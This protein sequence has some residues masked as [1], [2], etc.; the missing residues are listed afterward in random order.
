[1]TNDLNS[2]LPT[3]T[4]KRFAAT[5]HIVRPISFWV[6]LA[7]GAVSSLALFLAIFSRNATAQATT[8]SVMGFGVFLGI[9]GIVYMLIH[10]FT[11]ETTFTALDNHI[12]VVFETLKYRL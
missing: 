9:I 6:Q 10:L 8:N 1:M 4:K 2:Y 11:T 5:F 12:R 7:L 3:P